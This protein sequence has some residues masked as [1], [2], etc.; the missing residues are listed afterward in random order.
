MKDP[1][2]YRS[3]LHCHCHCACLSLE[4]PSAPDSNNRLLVGV[5][6]DILVPFP[7]SGAGVDLNSLPPQEPLAAGVYLNLMG[8]C[9]DTYSILAKVVT[10]VD[11]HA[12]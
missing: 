7:A 8:V 12:H 10:G 11:V 1:G 4:N 5:G 2:L 3:P 9:V 6:L